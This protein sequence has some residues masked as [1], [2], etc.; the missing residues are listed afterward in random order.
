MTRKRC[1]ISTFS[2]KQIL[3]LT[4][5][6]SS[7]FDDSNK[8][9]FVSRE[10]AL[11]KNIRTEGKITEEKVRNAVIETER[12]YAEMSAESKFIEGL[13]PI[14]VRSPMKNKWIMEIVRHRDSGS[15]FDF[16]SADDFEITL[17]DDDYGTVKLYFCNQ[18]TINRPD[19]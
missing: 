16:V 12:A 5:K 9:I 14:L 17:S 2:L 11:D 8:G 4:T 3:Q 7:F 6:S 1:E 13:S 10:A 15:V 19:L 18:G